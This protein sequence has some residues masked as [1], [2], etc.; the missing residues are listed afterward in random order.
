[1]DTAAG[2]VS[3]TDPGGCELPNAKSGW[4][5]DFNQIAYRSRSY[6]L[7][8]GVNSGDSRRIP[9]QNILRGVQVSINRLAA[10]RTDPKPPGKLDSST[11]KAGLDFQG[12]I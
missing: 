9:I 3:D 12:E 4:A 5:S 8:I 1:M 10:L 7:S 6:N 11:A 2:Q